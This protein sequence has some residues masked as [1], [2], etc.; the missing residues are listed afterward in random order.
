M[1]TLADV[2]VADD[3]LPGNPDTAR[4]AL[5]EAVSSARSDA[6]A[7]TAPTASP[8]PADNEVDLPEKFRGKSVKDVV[9]MYQNLES[10]YGTVANDL[11]VQR[12]LTDRL[13][14]L[15]RDTDLRR[16]TPPGEAEKPPTPVTASDLLDRPQETLERAISARVAE[17]TKPLHERLA[18]METASAQQ[19]FASRH[20]DFQ[21]VTADP[22]FISWVKGSQIRMRAAAA[23]HSGNWAIADE[24]LS[25]FKDSKGSKRKTDATVET[26]TA[27]LAGA[28]KASLETSGNAG[29]SNGTDGRSS[30]GKKVYRRTDLMRLRITDPEAYYDEGFQAEIL[31]AHAEGRVR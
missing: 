26:P 10:R 8:A 19:H 23:A 11:G 25:E 14:D 22:E 1:T 3:E 20:P 31:Q 21:Q 30:G 13:L 18:N 2:F 24:L 17:A 4:A 6:P 9:A 29:G 7:A 16:N 12:Q 5:T 27:D 15:K 28:R